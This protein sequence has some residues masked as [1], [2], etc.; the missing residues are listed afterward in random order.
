MRAILF[1]TIPPDGELFDGFYVALYLVA[2]SNRSSQN[3]TGGCADGG[4]S[5]IPCKA[6]FIRREGEE[7]RTSHKNPGGLLARIIL[8]DLSD[9]HDFA[10]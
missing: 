10:N 5:R 2:V 7:P 8:V 4:T 3:Y 9:R 6:M 1:P